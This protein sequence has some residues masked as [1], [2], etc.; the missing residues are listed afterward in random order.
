MHAEAET[1]SYTL[2]LKSLIPYH[3]MSEESRSDIW[4]DGLHLTPNGYCVMGD[5]VANQV[6]ELQSMLYARDRGV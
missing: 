1:F 6:V 3:A 4:D 5:H 2:D